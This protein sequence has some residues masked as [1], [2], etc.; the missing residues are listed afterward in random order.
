MQESSAIQC[1]NS[2]VGKSI[3]IKGDIATS[4]PL[5]VYG[6]V[7]GTISAPEHRVTIGRE[8]KVMADITACEVVI[9]GHVCGHVDVAHRAEIRRDGSFT[10]DLCA[11]RVFI[12]DGAVFHGAVDVRKANGTANAETDRAMEQVQTASTPE[13]EDDREAWWTNLAVSEPA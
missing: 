3:V 13:P 1:E 8:G 6:C 2:T 11:D 5:Y 7:D 12:E 9:M 4:D 10:G